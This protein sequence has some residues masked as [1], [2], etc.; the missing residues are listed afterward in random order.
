MIGGYLFGNLHRRTSLPRHV[1]PAQLL[2]RQ[3]SHMFRQQR[4]RCLLI[5]KSALQH[6]GR[7][8]DRQT[9]GELQSFD[10]RLVHG[11]PHFGYVT[12]A[13]FPDR[14]FDVLEFRR[15]FEGQ[16][17][18]VKINFSRGRLGELPRQRSVGPTAAEGPPLCLPAPGQRR[19]RGIRVQ[20]G[21]F[22][23]NLGDALRGP[24]RPAI[25]RQIGGQHAFDRLACKRLLFPLAVGKAKRP[26]EAFALRLRRFCAFRSLG[27]PLPVLRPLDRLFFPH[28]HRFVLR[29]RDLK[30]DDVQR[31]IGRL[32]APYLHG[33]DAQ[34]AVRPRNRHE[35]TPSIKRRKAL[36]NKQLAP[37]GDVAELA[38]AL[39]LGSS[40]ATRAGSSPVIPI[41]LM[42]SGFNASGWLDG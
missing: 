34:N 19:D 24:S 23:P 18:A 40:G 33:L 2:R 30:A 22:L 15:R 12:P 28:V 26:V 9:L 31:M 38:D 39:D 41:V 6:F 14:S 3:E 11:G 7:K 32:D 10:G 17:E 27:N 35:K 1:P 20:P 8:F 42:R 4:S 16:R 29:F 21:K 36:K 25:G 13:D 5:P 37:N